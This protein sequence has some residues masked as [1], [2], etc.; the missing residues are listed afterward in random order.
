MTKTEGKPAAKAELN[1]EG[2]AGEPPVVAKRISS[3]KCTEAACKKNCQTDICLKYCLKCMEIKT[4]VVKYVPGSGLVTVMEK[5]YTHTVNAVQDHAKFV[6]ATLDHAK[7]L[8]KMQKDADNYANGGLRSQYCAHCKKMCREG[9]D[10]KLQ[11][12]LDTCVG[13]AACLAM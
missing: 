11:T 6:D 5:A 2:K 12:C 13:S 1:A 4:E 3:D 10:N 9:H 7:D 8:E